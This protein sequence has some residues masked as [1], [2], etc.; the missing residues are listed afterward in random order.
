MIKPRKKNA[1]SKGKSSEQQERIRRECEEGDGGWKA[2]ETS[3]GYSLQRSETGQEEK[4]GPLSP[5]DELLLLMRKINVFI[6]KTEKARRMVGK[7]QRNVLQK[8]REI[9]SGMNKK[10]ERILKKIEGIMKRHEGMLNQI[11]TVNQC[12]DECLCNVLLAIRQNE[13]FQAWYP[14]Q[15][16]KKE[17]KVVGKYVV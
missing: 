8:A 2:P 7:S 6:N 10:E 14:A 9:L 5:D 13:F 4:I 16:G 11:L 15:N 12:V 17:Q 1:S 3:C